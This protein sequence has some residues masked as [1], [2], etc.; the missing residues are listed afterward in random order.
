M[1]NK[2]FTLI[3]LLLV[4]WIGILLIGC[5][6]W[7]CNVWELCHCDFEAPYKAE[8]CRSLGVVIVPMGMIEGFITIKDGEPNGIM[9]E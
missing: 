2:G 1:K 8:V 9:P 5:V 7:V 3:E 4:V 6:G